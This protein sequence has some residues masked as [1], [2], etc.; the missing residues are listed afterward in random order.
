MVNRTR[1]PNDLG[2]FDKLWRKHVSVARIRRARSSVAMFWSITR[3]VTR[4]STCWRS[5]PGCRSASDLGTAG[6]Y[7]TIIGAQPKGLSS[8]LIVCTPSVNQRPTIE[9]QL[10][11]G[12]VMIGRPDRVR[13]VFVV[14]SQQRQRGVPHDPAAG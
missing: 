10:G 6:L 1:N 5:T 2:L 9:K 7:L 12:P 8:G 3:S 13:A 14:I 11:V 4:N